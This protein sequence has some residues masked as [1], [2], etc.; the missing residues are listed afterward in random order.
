MQLNLS[1]K[2]FCLFLL[3]Q[4]PFASDDELETML[5][6]YLPEHFSM[7]PGEWWE[8][9]TGK[10]EAPWDGYTYVH[11]LNEAVTFF[12]EFHPNETIYF[13][14]DTYLGNTGG[15][16]HLSLLRWTELQAI[17]SKDE[18][19]PSLLFFMLLP[20]VAGN[21]SELAEI[22]AAIT[23]HLKEMALELPA[24]QLEI[25]TR[26]LGSHLIFGEEESDIFEHLPDTGWAINRNHSERNRRNRAED[27]RSI[28]Q[29]IGS[30][31]L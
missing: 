11:R 25:L 2:N 22:T 16:F 28:N 24:D 27:L 21:R 29:L 10:T 4:F 6:D 14:N 5:T 18:T 30:A 1:D 20:L 17:I 19:D 15:N 31:T 7:P 9:L 8:E 13:F 23:D 3:T 12:A 26:F